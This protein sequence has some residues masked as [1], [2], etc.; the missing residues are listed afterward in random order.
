MAHPVET[1]WEAE[2]GQVSCLSCASG[3]SGGFKI[4]QGYAA[5]EGEFEN[6][7]KEKYSLLIADLKE[8]QETSNGFFILAIL[9]A[10]I[11]LLSQIVLSKGQKA[12]MELQTVD[13]RG[14]QQQKMMMW[15]MPIMMAIFSFMY[16]ATF[17]IYMILSQA[18]TIVFTLLV[19]YLIDRK[20][21]KEHPERNPGKIHGRVYTPEVKEEPKSRKNKKEEQTPDF[22]NGGNKHLRGRK[23]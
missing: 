9:T 18:M 19:N 7:N 21:A 20:F 13:G 8:E 6:M 22:I 15:M 12:A 5:N 16:T 11:S 14:A 1:M 23:K 2:A 10:G 4:M 3:N 17:S